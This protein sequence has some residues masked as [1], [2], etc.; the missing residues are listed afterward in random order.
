MRAK[1]IESS[2][3][4]R[5]SL[6]NSSDSVFNGSSQ[7]EDSGKGLAKEEEIKLKSE[8]KKNENN[9]NKTRE[10]AMKRWRDG[11]RDL[12]EFLWRIWY[13]IEDFFFDAF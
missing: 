12:E 3:R 5:V 7:Q 2:I 13:A 8:K 4:T 10:V 1:T 11:E 6:T 9:N